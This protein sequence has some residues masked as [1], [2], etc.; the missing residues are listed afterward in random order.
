MKLS[1][2]LLAA[3]ALGVAIGSLT[4]SCEQQDQVPVVHD[5]NCPDDCTSEHDGHEGGGE[6][7][8]GEMEWCP[9]CG[10]G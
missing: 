10:M 7:G 2:N 4:T 6:E 1:S 3:I 9:A 8:G 5:L